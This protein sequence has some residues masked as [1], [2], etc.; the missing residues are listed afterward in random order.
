MYEINNGVGLFIDANGEVLY[1]LL[2]E[3]IP[4]HLA[5]VENFETMIYDT[6]KIPVTEHRFVCIRRIRADKITYT[7]GYLDGRHKSHVRQR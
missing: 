7:H 2:T 5:K 6:V 4:V 1:G 3:N